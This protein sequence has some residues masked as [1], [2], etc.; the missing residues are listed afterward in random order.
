MLALPFSPVVLDGEGVVVGSPSAAAQ[1][2]LGRGILTKPPG[3]P[4]PLP[5]D[6]ACTVPVRSSVAP[7]A[8]R[9][10]HWTRRPRLAFPGRAI[11][12]FPL[13]DVS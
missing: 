8:R 11:I 2:S 9:D 6:E 12:L 4:L 7:N 13:G 1:D 10:L 3:V 5:P